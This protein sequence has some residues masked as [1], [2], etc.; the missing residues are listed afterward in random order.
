MCLLTLFFFSLLAIVSVCVCVCACAGAWP[1]GL[2]VMATLQGEREK[3]I[4]QWG[5]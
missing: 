4:R 2:T 5:G 3:M 1:E